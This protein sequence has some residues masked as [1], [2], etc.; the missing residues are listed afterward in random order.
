MGKA[1]SPASC[2]GAHSCPPSSHREGQ[3]GTGHHAW[4]SL[5]VSATLAPHTPFLSCDCHSVPALCSVLADSSPCSDPRGAFP[6]RGALTHTSCLLRAL[7]IE[8]SKAGVTEC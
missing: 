5:Q 1:L 4:P 7:P 6:S 2:L 8:L 3:G